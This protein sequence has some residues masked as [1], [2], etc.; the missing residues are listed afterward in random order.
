L[1]IIGLGGAGCRIAESFSQYPEYKGIYK[2]DSSEHKGAGKFLKIKEYKAPED[3]EKGCPPMKRFFSKL[4]DEVVFIVGG[5]GRCSLMSLAILEKIKD[6]KITVVFVKPDSSL[7]SEEKRKIGR[8]VFGVLQEYSR[9][10]L[11]DSM[12]IVDNVA[13]QNML[14]DVPIMNLLDKMNT[15]IVSTLHMINVYGNIDSVYESKIDKPGTCR[16][17]TVGLFEMGE[18]E[19]K[20]MFDLDFTRHKKYFYC[21]NH[22]RLNKDGGLLGVVNSQMKEQASSDEINVSFGVYAT[23]YQDDY[24]YTIWHTNKV[25]DWS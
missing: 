3:Y 9:S 21:I 2:I 8:T 5:S 23:N 12:L 7:L 24:V 10:G 6:R 19:N 18:S 17:G 14:D 16:V 20:M 13:V 15:F 1:D 22:E 4:G 11:F 25:Q